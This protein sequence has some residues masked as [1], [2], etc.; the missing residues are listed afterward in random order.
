MSEFWLI[1][2]KFLGHVVS[3]SGVLVDPE[4]VEAIM[5]WERQKS[6]F[7][8]HSFLGLVGY[9]KRFIEDFSRLAVPMTRLTHKGVKFEW[10]NLC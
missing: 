6:V 7:K 10:T 9:Y 1:E 8:I 2:V 5:S 3:D 4:K